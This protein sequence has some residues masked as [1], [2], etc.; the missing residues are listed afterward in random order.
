MYVCIC[1]YFSS[2][3][4]YK[5]FISIFLSAYSIKMALYSL[6]TYLDHFKTIFICF[7]ALEYG[8]IFLLQPKEQ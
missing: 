7:N 5:L 1:M 6:P 4:V 3:I 8:F 2:Q